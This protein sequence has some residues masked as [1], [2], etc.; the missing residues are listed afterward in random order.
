MS[1]T[2]KEITVTGRTT[3][4]IRTAVK[5]WF[6]ENKIKAIEST[7]NSIKGKWGTGF[8]TAPKYYQV[9]FIPIEGGVLAQTEGWVTIYGINEQDFAPST[10]LAGGVPRKEGWKTME[11]L[12]STLESL[13]RK[14]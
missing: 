7:A 13:S 11:R 2:K 14:P 3:E 12:W 1:R 10:M 9:S 4:E 5:N 8:L 6:N